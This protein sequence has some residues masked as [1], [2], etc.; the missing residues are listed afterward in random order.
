MVKSIGSKN[1]K[2]TWTSLKICE[3]N[4]WRRYRLCVRGCLC[5]SCK[6]EV[7]KKM[8][9]RGR[10]QTPTKTPCVYQFIVSV[11]GGEGTSNN[12]IVCGAPWP[13]AWRGKTLLFS[14]AKV[15]EDR[16]GR[17]VEN[18][19]W[20]LK[21]WPWPTT[22]YPTDIEQQCST[23]ILD[24]TFIMYMYKCHRQVAKESWAYMYESVVCER[25]PK[26]ATARNKTITWNTGGML[27]KKIL[28]P[29]ENGSVGRPETEK[30]LVQPYER[31][32]RKG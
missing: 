11:R 7:G 3:K 18:F 6:R 12:I 1:E 31:L 4:W 25:M 5:G 16:V 22:Q 13:T 23:P 2:K 29:Q 19:L 10:S 32:K 17:S 28:F 30:F 26:T 8:H 21:F 24:Y 15:D 14:V 20:T 27:G 9:A